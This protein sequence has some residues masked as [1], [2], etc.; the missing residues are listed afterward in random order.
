MTERLA[1]YMSTSWSM[2]SPLRGTCV[3]GEERLNLMP[4]TEKADAEFKSPRNR[5]GRILGEKL[6]KIDTTANAKGGRD[7][8]SLHFGVQ[9][10]T[11][12]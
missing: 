11:T 10:P 12:R 4:R 7:V 3:V 9:N 1:P 6:R 5:V 8:V 2:E